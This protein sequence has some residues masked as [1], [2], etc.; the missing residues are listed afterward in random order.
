MSSTNSIPPILFR[1]SGRKVVIFTVELPQRQPLSPV[2]T[3]LDLVVGLVYEQTTVE[4]VVFQRIDERNILLVFA[5]GE[6]IDELCKKMQTIEIWLCQSVH[7]YLTM[8]SANEVQQH[9]RD[10]LFHGLHKQLR[11]LM[12]N[13]YDDARITYPQ[14]VTVAWKAESEK[15][16]HTE[17]SIRVRS[18]QAEG[19]DDNAKL[20]EQ[21]AQMQLVV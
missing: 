7:T 2:L 1:E 6:N 3:N 4:P 16:D 17:E 8:L 18:V 19:K 20:S 5:E 12:H 11:D 15:E 10:R 9:L 13:L 14:L 21:I